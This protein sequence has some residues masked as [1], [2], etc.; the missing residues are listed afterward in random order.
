ME[1]MYVFAQADTKTN[2]SA[3]SHRVG[4]EDETVKLFLKPGIFHPYSLGRLSWDMW[5]ALLLVYTALIVP[6]SIAFQDAVCD[7]EVTAF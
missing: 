4:N 1:I 3:T 2:E 6:Y 5:I 7:Q